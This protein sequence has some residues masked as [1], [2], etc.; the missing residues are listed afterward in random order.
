MAAASWVADRPTGPWP[1]IA[2]VSRPEV[3]MRRSAP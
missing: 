2:I 3:C 1:K